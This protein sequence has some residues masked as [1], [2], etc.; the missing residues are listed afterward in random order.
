MVALAARLGASYPFDPASTLVTSPLFSPL[1]LA[2]LRLLFAVYTTT[3]LIIT[4]ID[5]VNNGDGASFLSYFTH[6][7][8]IGVCS[9]MWA[10]GVQTIVYALR[11][12]RGRPDKGYPLQKWPAFLQVLHI[13]LFSTITTFPIIV[14][15]VYWALLTSSNTFATTFNAWNNVSVHAMNSGFALFEI[16]LTH[17]APPPWIHA[18]LV[19]LL[20]ACYLGVA[21]ITYATQGFYTYSF[22]NPSKEHGYLAAYIVGIGAAGFII[23]ALARTACALRTR[24][25]PPRAV[26]PDGSSPIVERIKREGPGRWSWRQ[27]A[28]AHAGGTHP[29]VQPGEEQGLEDWEIVETRERNTQGPSLA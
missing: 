22:L 28:N 5:D 15:A 1:V 10:A 20:L 9:Y 29:Y 17:V 21:Y 6:L 26:N 23:F 4:L 2:F 11:V 24:F 16:F 19:F 8:Y 18:L 27:S 14:T 12:R 25:F 7:S 3:V 13:L